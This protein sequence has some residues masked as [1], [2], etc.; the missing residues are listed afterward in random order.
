MKSSSLQ[1]SLLTGYILAGGKSTRLMGQ[2]KGLLSWQGK[3]F[4]EHI[5]QVIQPFVNQIVVVANQP[6]YTQLG[7]TTI[8]D[9][10]TDCGPLAG[11]EAAL[12]HASAK[13][14]YCLIISCDTPL[15]T[16]TALGYLIKQAETTSARAIIASD[17]QRC[18]PLLG[19]YAKNLLPNI[20]QYLNQQQFKLQAF[21][22]TLQPAVQ[23]VSLQK[24]TRGRFP[25]LFNINTPN[26][27]ADLLKEDIDDCNFDFA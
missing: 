2:P 4:I 27:Y 20:T 1:S 11:I 17:G 19:L 21:I 14:N 12:S 5:A 3:T 7:F 24:F 23:I 13:T 15:I 9:L 26:H 16:R 22:E 6:Q 10:R 18:H 8:S 25:V